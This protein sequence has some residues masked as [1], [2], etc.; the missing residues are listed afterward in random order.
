[1]TKLSVLERMKQLR[2]NNQGGLF[3]VIAGPRLSGKT[4]LAGTLPGKTV[5]LYPELEE[6]GPG[7]AEELAA[8]LGNDLTVVTFRSIYT[9]TAEAP[10]LMELISMLREDDE[11][12]NI[13]ID[14]ISA[15]S[16]MIYSQSDVQ[17]LLKKNVWDGFRDI[18]D[19]LST[20][21]NEIKILTTTEVVKHKNVFITMALSPKL[22]S[23]GNMIDVVF[24]VKG[25]V[26]VT[27]ITKKCPFVGVLA[28]AEVEG[29]DERV[30]LTQTFAGWPARIDGLLDD[31][32]PGFVERNLGQVLNLLKKEE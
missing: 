2:R 15:I 13:Y 24:D 31:D 17:V 23:A 7:S 27:Q 30:L 10:S 1:M 11:I 3:G 32:N 20:I 16:D 28:T 9:G 14:G 21:M 22:D 29:K 19:K 4:T 8:K 25:N 18:G 6:A 26:A 5:L 12:D